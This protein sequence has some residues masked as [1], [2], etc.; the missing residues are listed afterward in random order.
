M[1]CSSPLSLSCIWLLSTPSIS[2]KPSPFYLPATHPLPSS[3][4]PPS[5]FFPQ[6][7]PFHLP[8][9]HP[10]LSSHN[11]PPNF[12]QPF[13]FPFPLSIL[14]YLPTI[15][16]VHFPSISSLLTQR[17]AK[18]DRSFFWGVISASTGLGTLTMGSL[19]SALQGMSEV[20]RAMCTVGRVESF[21]L[22]LMHA[23]PIL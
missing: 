23:E 6:P 14:F 21:E 8:K 9:T 12:P 4:N 17:I 7:T 20:G 5:S 18:E 22:K 1:S 11:L 3:L 13:P 10:L 19:G 15:P 16:G 2:P